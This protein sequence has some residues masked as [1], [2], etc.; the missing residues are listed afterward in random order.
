MANI[1]LTDVDLLLLYQGYCARLAEAESVDAAVACCAEVLE[2]ALAPRVLQ[3]V[4]DGG[5]AR[6]VLGPQAGEPLRQPGTGQLAA[7]ARGELAVGG[8][9]EGVTRCFAPLRVRGALSGWVCLEDLALTP[10]S[11]AFVTSIALQTAPVLALLEATTGQDE[12]VIQLETLGEVGRLLSGVLDLDALLEAIYTVTVR[13]VDA[14]FFYI[15][16]YDAD[17]DAFDLAYLV[18]DGQ[19]LPASERWSAQ[20]GLAGVVVRERQALCVT[21]YTAECERRGVPPRM[22]GDLT[23]CRAWLGVP[24]IARDQ[25]IGVIT[26]GSMREGYAYSPAHVELFTTIA[27]QAAVAIENARLYQ[28]SERQA[29]Q[30]RALNHIGRTITSTL[31][32]ERVPSLIMEQVSELLNVEEGSLLVTDDESGDLVFAYTIGPVGSQLI[33]QRLRRGTGLA[34]FVAE[35]GQSVLSNDVQ[36]DERFDDST[37]R[38]TGYTTRAILATPLRGV[39]GVRGVIEVLNRRDGKPFTSED[40]RLLEAVSDYAAIAL[41][42]ARRFGEVDKALA[43]RAE[44]LARTNDQLQHNLRSLTAL[45]ALGMAINTA[46]RT[47]EEI[48]GMTVRGVAE[49]TGALGAG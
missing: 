21:D 31:D 23:P 49:M 11:A 47:A 2:R 14:L 36:R 29:R 5:R 35:S 7:L 6:R 16:L 25:A 34:G 46:L 28:R 40:Q 48:F 45:N 10:E 32:P 26:I 39:G 19:R 22:F 18:S 3:I 13:L 20:V 30:L 27:T 43:R 38:S 24:L 37:D 42:N 4:W 33:G 12:R 9:A 1:A 44:E 15:A 41:E 8:A 17:S